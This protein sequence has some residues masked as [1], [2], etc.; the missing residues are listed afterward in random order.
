MAMPKTRD[1]T[2]K[3]A[4]VNKESWE[5]LLTTLMNLNDKSYGVCAR[6][7]PYS[8]CCRGAVNEP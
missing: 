3:K 6:D 7:R 8:V 5:G 4:I 2:N 1:S